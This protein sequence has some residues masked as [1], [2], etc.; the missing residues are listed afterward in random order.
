MGVAGVL[1]ILFI[2]LVEALLHLKLSNDSFQKYR[3]IKRKYLKKFY[4]EFDNID[5]CSKC[6]MKESSYILIIL[7]LFLFIVSVIVVII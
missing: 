3:T 5:I 4:F 6:N 7:L 1:L 2:A